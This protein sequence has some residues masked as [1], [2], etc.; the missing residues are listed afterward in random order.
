MSCIMSISRSIKVVSCFPQESR[1]GRIFTAA[2]FPFQRFS[3][4]FTTCACACVCVRVCVRACV[5]E[6]ERESVCVRVCVCV[7]VCVRARL[8]TCV[9]AG[10]CVCVCELKIKHLS[11]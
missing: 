8:C 9:Y 6:R 10:V 5:C 1:F 2:G 7:H 3:A 11:T 4:T